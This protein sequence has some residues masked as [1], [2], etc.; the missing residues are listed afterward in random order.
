MRIAALC[1]CLTACAS[2]SAEFPIEAEPEFSI[3]AEPEF[4][5]D[6]QRDPSVCGESNR[7]GLVAFPARCVRR[8]IRCQL[9]I[10]PHR[11]GD[12]HHNACADREPPNKYPGHDVVVSGPLIPA[13]YF[14]ALDGQG[15][16]WEVK[17]DRWS[18]YAEWLQELL[19]R[20]YLVMILRDAAT[21]RA[22]GLRY[23]VGTADLGLVRE[24]RQGLGRATR[25]AGIE[26]RHLPKCLR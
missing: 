14:D 18:T 5:I 23:V 8:K 19:T 25:R 26:I 10:T 6:A 13:R 7:A 12:P 9:A 4:P 3:E 21:A 16:L 17:T 11:G 15:A 20:R 1:L 24:L 22:C 2:A